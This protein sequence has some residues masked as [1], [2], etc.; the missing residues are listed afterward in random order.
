MS[1]AK[2]CDVDLNLESGLTYNVEFDDG[3]TRRMRDLAQKVQLCHAWLDLATGQVVTLT[4]LIV[5]G[6]KGPKPLAFSNPEVANDFSRYPWRENPRAAF[7]G[8]VVTR[9]ALDIEL[10]A[11]LSWAS[12]AGG[13]RRIKTGV[14][15][16]VVP[17]GGLPDRERFPQLYKSSGV[18]MP[19]TSTSYVVRVPGKTPKSAGTTYWPRVSSLTAN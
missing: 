6:R 11:Q 1:N 17:V 19:R 8:A 2:N 7:G 4:W 18:G 10:G 12:Q 15:E 3:S 14:V 13:G 16:E 9:M 5:P